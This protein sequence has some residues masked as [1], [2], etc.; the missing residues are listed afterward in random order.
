M[1]TVKSLKKR[2]ASKFDV[3]IQSIVKCAFLYIFGFFF[4]Q[5]GRAQPTG[6]TTGLA[7]NFGILPIWCPAG[8]SLRPNSYGEVEMSVSAPGHQR[9]LARWANVAGGGQRQFEDNRQTA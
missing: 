6:L 5:H 1:G 2:V 3:M 7:Q 8:V 9:A 4:K